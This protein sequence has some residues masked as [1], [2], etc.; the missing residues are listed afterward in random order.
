MVAREGF[1]FGKEGIEK[2]YYKKK[3]HLDH[4]NAAFLNPKILLK[5][6]SPK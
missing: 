6:A 3:P 2:F 5:N 1:S 4:R